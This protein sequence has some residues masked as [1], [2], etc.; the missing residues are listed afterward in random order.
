MD[1]NNAPAMRLERVTP[2][3]AR[4]WLQRINAQRRL[5]ERTVAGYAADMRAG[6]WE[7][8]ITPIVFDE[9]GDL[10]NGQHRLNAVIE[11]N[12]EQS[13]WVRRG[14]T[15]NSIFRMDQGAPRRTGDQLTIK[16]ISYGGSIA[17]IAGI[18]A[19][20]HL[21]PDVVWGTHTTSQV[22]KSM[23]LDIALEKV[24][25][26]SDALVVGR[27]AFRA[28]RAHQSSYAVL[29]M[30]VAEG[31]SYTEMWADFHWG[32]TTGAELTQVDPRLA[33][34]TYSVRPDAPKWGSGQSQLFAAIKTWNAYV[35]D[36]SVRMLKAPR[37][38]ELP[39][40]KVK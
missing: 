13:F 11:S 3:T 39:M 36:K 1:H 25:E 2:D 12:L 14:V 27:E 4:E 15:A 37:K 29:S 21:L 23:I 28:T 17:T 8:D 20:Y 31:S 40:P 9:N 6:R 24:E 30:L 7:E 22:T 33:F 18:Y 38:S 5:K 34:R 16:G 26:M 35:D 32:V 10:V 19:K